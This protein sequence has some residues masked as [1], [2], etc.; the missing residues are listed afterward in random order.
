MRS[1]RWARP[2][3]PPAPTPSAIAST[4]CPAIPKLS[5]RPAVH[6]I[7]LSRWTA[8]TN[9]GWVPSGRTCPTPRPFLIN[10]DHHISNTRFGQ[11]NW[12]DPVSGV[13]RRD[14]FADRRSA[15]R[16]SESRDRHLP[17]L[18]H[19]GRHAGLPHAEHHAAPIAVRRTLHGGRRFVVREHRSTIQSPVAGAGVFVGQSASMP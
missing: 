8:A 5:R 12:I 6:S 2:S 7:W 15:R 11:I 1:E 14:G 17:A 10:I 16:A 3:H 4:F 18:W 13:Y 19:R 9:C